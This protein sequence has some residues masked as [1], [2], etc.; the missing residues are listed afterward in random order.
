MPLSIVIPCFNERENI[1]R[2]SEELFPTLESLKIPFEVIA[3]DDG[4]HDGTKEALESF[5]NLKKIRLISHLSNRGLG[6]ALKSGFLAAHGNWIVTLDCDLTFSPKDIA[7]LLSCQKETGADMVSGSP[8][9]GEDNL[10]EI[11]WRR[12]IPS[13]IL[14]AFYRVFLGAPFSSFTPI[15]RLYRTSALKTLDLKSDGFQINAEIAAFFWIK[16]FKIVE[17]P[18]PLSLRRLGKSK[19]NPLRELIRHAYLIGQLVKMNG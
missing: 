1:E 16:K 18:T 3:V 2:F 5:Q 9:I 17:T 8:L 11:S 14:N 19:L 6:A 13:R 12:Q 10:C 4:S 15:F 7:R